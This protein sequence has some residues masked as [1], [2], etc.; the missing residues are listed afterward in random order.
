[1]ILGDNPN[2][3]QNTGSRATLDDLFRRT[4]TRRPDALALIDPPDRQA[5]T[6][7]PPRRLTYAQADRMVSAIAGRLRRLDLQTDAVIG[8]QLPNV[9]ESVLTLLAVLRAGMIAAPLPLLWRRAECAAALARLGAKALICCGRVGAADH[10][11]LARHVAAGTFA[12]R[13]VGGF[14]KNLPDGVI[15]FDDLYDVDTPELLSA[16]ERGGNPA[17]HVAVVTWDVS[18]DAAGGGLVPVGRSHAELLAGGMA[19]VLESR[20]VPEGVILSCVPAHSFAGLSL[21]LSQWLFTG[22]TLALHHAFDPD[23]FAA[24][25]AEHDCDLAVLPGPMLAPLG[26][27]GLLDPFENLKAVQAVWRAPERLAGSGAWHNPQTPVVDILVFGETGLIPARRDLDGK[28]A[29]IPLGIVTAPRGTTGGIPVAEIKRGDAGTIL[30][31]GGM[32]PH[33][34]YPLHAER[35]AWEREYRPLP[36]SSSPISRMLKK[37]LPLGPLA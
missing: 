30:M 26:E 7:D 6:G 35:G 8:I 17:A 23:V 28:P 19:C 4:A 11:E 32:V 2:A 14:G 34:P 9:V 16:T 15:P 36:S 10:G 24:Q 18:S 5:V 25:C 1:M 27:V 20:S 37:G 13:H 31:R 12:I 33:H 21:T 3:P 22:G 29:A